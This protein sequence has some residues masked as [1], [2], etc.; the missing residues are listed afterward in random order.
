MENGKLSTFE[1]IAIVLTITLTHSVL[2]LPKAIMQT[3]RI[4]FPP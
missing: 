2:T 1:A 4:L 3:S